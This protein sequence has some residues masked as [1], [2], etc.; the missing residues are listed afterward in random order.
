MDQNINLVKISHLLDLAENNLLEARKLLFEA[1][2]KETAIDLKNED[3]II[4]GIF[5]GEEMV[6][7]AGKR[8][9]VPVNYASKSK[10]VAGDLLKLTVKEDGS[11]LYKQIK[12][13]SRK[14]IIGILSRAGGKYLVRADGKNY[15]I[16]TASVTY[17]QAKAGDKVAILIPI[18]GENNWAA[19][20]NIVEQ[21]EGKT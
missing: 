18:G 15:H 20:E 3:R 16:L 9:P 17:H 8:Y 11:F 19:L 1:S 2:Q 13:A 5:N 4:E 10:L 14:K 12:P 21:K 7:V 6:T